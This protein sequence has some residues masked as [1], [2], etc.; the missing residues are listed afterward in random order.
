MGTYGVIDAINIMRVG[1]GIEID[2]V[3]GLLH[4]IEEGEAQVAARKAKL[5]REGETEVARGRSRAGWQ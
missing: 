5:M 2:H 4:T 1:W 3:G